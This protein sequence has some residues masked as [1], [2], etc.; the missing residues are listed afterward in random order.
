MWRR[1]FGSTRQTWQDITIVSGL[2]RSGTSMMMRMLEAGGMAVVVD[3][4][5]APDT[6]NPY[7][8]YEFE[9]VKQIKDDASFLDQAHGK[10]LKMVFTLL[11][12]L[13][14]NKT[15]RVIFMQRNM[16]EVLR[17]QRIMLQR[18]GKH[19]QPN[20][21]ARMGQLFAKHL[22]EV[23]AWLARQTLIK[24][25]YVNYDEVLTAPLPNA[26]RVNKF[27]G[28]RLDSQKMA[29]VVDPTLYRNRV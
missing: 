23:Y 22:E 8:Y 15:Y 2:P 24:V 11:Y 26:Q 9:P 6:D 4:M 29:A 7:G 19:I 18:Q 21:D 27:L 17:S 1:I 12:D 13:P 25:M 28:N 5:R 10:A 3:N 20:D 14:Q 16:T